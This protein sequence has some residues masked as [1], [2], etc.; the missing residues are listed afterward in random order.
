[1]LKRTDIRLRDPFVLPHERTRTY[2]L[3]GTT[4]ANVWSGPATGFDVYRS[5]DLEHWE[6]PFP[7]FRPGPGFWADRNYWA[8]EVHVY[9]GR[10]YMFASFKA[11]GR[12]RG[13]QILAA[14]APEGPF[15]PLT[16]GPV[17]PPEWECLDGTLHIDEAGTPWIVFCREWLQVSDGEMHAMRLSPDLTAAAGEPVLLFRASQAPWTRPSRDGHYVTDGPFLFPGRDGSLAMLWS[18][19]GPKG[20]AMG[21]ARSL[22]GRVTGPWEHDANA[23]FD[24]DGGHGMLFRTFEGLPMVAIHKPNKSALERPHFLAWSDGV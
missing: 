21:V 16:E 7:A 5:A 2:Y 15:A 18:S 1:M 19:I 3:Y 22:S 20:Y 11:E 6:G 14:D 9:G 23:A 10:Y 17:T 24:E 4:D 12:C 13:T 8:P